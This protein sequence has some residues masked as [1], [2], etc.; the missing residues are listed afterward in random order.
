MEDAQFDP[1]MDASVFN[2]QDHLPSASALAGGDHE[3]LGT[4]G[5]TVGVS[6][7]FQT[8]LRSRVGV[9]TLGPTATPPSWGSTP[10]IAPPCAWT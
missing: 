9:E 3:D 8:G 5:G 4:T 2:A 7:R 6:K 1:V 10:A